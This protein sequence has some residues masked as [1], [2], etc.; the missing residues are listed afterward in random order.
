M[1]VETCQC[2]I[3][4]LFNK[5]MAITYMVTGDW[6]LSVEQPSGNSCIQPQAVRCGGVRWGLT[7]KVDKESVAE[8]GAPPDR[9]EPKTGGLTST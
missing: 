7:S 2:G 4:T 9:K 5:H 3:A 1:I 8:V 6:S